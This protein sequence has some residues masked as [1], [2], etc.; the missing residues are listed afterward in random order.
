LTL[1]PEEVD[2]NVHPQK[3]EV[4]FQH[5]DKLR[6][7]VQKAVQDSFETLSMTSS[8]SVDFST[9]DF[10]EP[11][12]RFKESDEHIPSLWEEEAKVIGMIGPYLLIDASSVAGKNKEGILWVH[13]QKAQE[14]L[15]TQKLKDNKN[16]SQKLLI[17]IPVSLTQREALELE[18]KKALLHSMGFEID[19]SGKG[20][21]LIQAIPSFIENL[22]AEEALKQV[23]AS[24]DENQKIASFAVRK[25]KEF[26]LQEALAIWHQIKDSGDS[27]C[28]AKMEWN[29]IQKLFR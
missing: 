13:L 5:E 16:A 17:P 19:L 28:I 24:T 20:Q 3:K 2:V 21:Y 8:P 27:E 15:I 14:K 12:L 9:F 7:L 10:E 22:E 1:P 29:E 11:S 18:E 25:K 6:Q 23:I 26:M 4:R